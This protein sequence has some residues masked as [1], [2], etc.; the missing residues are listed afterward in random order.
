VLGS[1]VRASVGTVVVHVGP[2]P[3]PASAGPGG[4]PGSDRPRAGFI[5]G[6]PVGGSVVRSR[7]TRRL[8]HILAGLLDSLPPGTGVVVRALPGSADADSQRLAADVA[9]GLGRCLAKMGHVP[10]PVE[11]VTP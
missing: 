2:L 5:V 1:G 11:A 8:R 10:V 6:R 3:A 9:R 7:V 4:A